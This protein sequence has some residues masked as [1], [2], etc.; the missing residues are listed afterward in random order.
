MLE[1]RHGRI[2]YCEEGMGPT[3]VLV[4][5]SWASVAAWHG[6]VT[7]LGGRFR[8]VTTSLPGYGGT[9]ESRTLGDTSINRQ[10]EVVEAVVRRAGAPVHLVGHSLGALACLDV[11]LC[12]L[13]P[14]M[15]LTLIEPVAFSALRQAGELA[16]YEQF[17]VMREHYVRSFENGDKEAARHVVDYLAGRGQFDALHSRMREYIVEATPTHILDIHCDFD[18][19]LSTFANILLPSL[20]I[21]SG[22]TVPSLQRSSE[23]L[24]KAMANASLR[25]I[26]AG[27]HLLTNAHSGEL[28]QLIGEHV[29][30]VEALAWTS[31]CMDAPFAFVPRLTKPPIKSAA[32]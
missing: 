12:G 5:G 10:A 32:E 15:S 3:I 19:P 2:D 25:S 4:P 16:L 31:L 7:A 6:I 30:R 13:A 23:I 24:S 20:V 11:A 29:S 22:R 21:N 28:A 26:S 8:T 18:P 14:L 9:R 27:G 1:D 17:T